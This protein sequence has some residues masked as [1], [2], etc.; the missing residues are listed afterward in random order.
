MFRGYASYPDWSMVVSLLCA[1]I[2]VAYAA[3]AGSTYIGECR[4]QV[5]L[6]LERGRGA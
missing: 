1:A 2:R 3:S 5:E 6:I 4:S